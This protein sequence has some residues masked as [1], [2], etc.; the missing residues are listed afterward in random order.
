MLL[1]II[2]HYNNGFLPLNQFLSIISGIIKKKILVKLITR[3]PEKKGNPCYCM[4]MQY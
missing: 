2:I 3:A 4:S 1:S